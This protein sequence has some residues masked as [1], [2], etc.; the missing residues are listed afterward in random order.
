M[1][2]KKLLATRFTF[3][4]KKSPQS[5]LSSTLWRRKIRH[6][7]EKWNIL[8]P[9]RMYRHIFSIYG[10]SKHQ[11]TTLKASPS[12]ALNLTFHPKNSSAETV[13][14]VLPVVVEA[15]SPKNKPSL[16]KRKNISNAVIKPKVAASQ[17]INSI[18]SSRTPSRNFSKTK[19]NPPQFSALSTTKLTVEA[20][21]VQAFPRLKWAMYQST[22]A[23]TITA[24]VN[25]SPSTCL[26]S[27]TK[28]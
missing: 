2:K 24:R 27:Q 9:I 21:Q 23:A 26:L 7:P 3:K 12:L 19:E 22:V 20:S 15:L 5:S 10:S 11:S 28:R 17:Q 1:T 16:S 4:V 6:L 8:A 13:S 25:S 18:T 14:K